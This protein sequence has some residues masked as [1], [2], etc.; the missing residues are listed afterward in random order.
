MFRPL[1]LCLAALSLPPCLADSLSLKL[2]TEDLPPYNF[3]LPDGRV[4]GSSTEKV[5]ILLTRSNLAYK[6][7]LTPWAR[8]FESARSQPGHCVYSTAR[9]PEREASFVWIGPLAHND[10]MLF[11]RTDKPQ[12]PRSLESAIG[13]R[14]GG[15]HGSASALYMIKQG[16]NVVMSANHDISIKNLM[17]GRLDYWLASGESGNALIARQHLTGKIKPVIPVRS[18]ELYLACHPGTDAAVL[19]KLQQGFQLLQSDGTLAAIN[20]KYND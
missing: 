10:W 18:F 11:G 7:E 8:A 13:A 5:E 4:G 20:R 1:M 12:P 9:T 3:P 2:F 17:A 14:I 16:Y 6:I 19:H 15:Y